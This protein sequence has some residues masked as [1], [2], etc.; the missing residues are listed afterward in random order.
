MKPGNP[1]KH[2]AFAFLI[3]LVVYVIAYYSI[4]HRRTRN[5]PW[6]VTFTI[7][8]TGVA[9]MTINQPRLAITNLE[10]RFEDQKN[11][12]KEPSQTLIFDQPKVVPFAV[13]FG[14]CIFMDTTFLPG[15]VTFHLFSH[16][17]E[18]LPRTLII[19]HRENAWL[20]NAVIT[21][22]SNK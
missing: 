9:S 20:P 11:V 3:A 22:R 17:I 13:P 21:L 1:I 10:V 12:Q 14:E 15:A 18:L 8:P 7:D 6:Q 2:F 16:E 4:E 19:D 5:G